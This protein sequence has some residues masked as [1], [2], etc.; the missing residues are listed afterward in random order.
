MTVDQ[1]IDTDAPETSAHA[2]PVVDEPQDE[3]PAEEIPAAEV[4]AA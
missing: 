1:Q 3:T 4:E 2:A